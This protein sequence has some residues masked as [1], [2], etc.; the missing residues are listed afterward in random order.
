MRR[1][2]RTEPTMTSTPPSSRKV[3]LI[4]GVSSG[5]GLAAARTLAQAGFRVFGT[6]RRAIGGSVSDGIEMLALDVTDDASVERAVRA[7][8]DQAGRIDLLI[9]NA[10]IGIGAAAEESSVAQAQAL[11]DTN[12]FGTMRVTRAVLPHMR[13]QK[14][15]R[16]VNISSVLGFLPAPY[17]A[18]YAASKHAVEGYSES[19]DHEMRTLG[20]RVVLVQP[21]YTATDF[22]KNAL[23]PDQPLPV[24]D[25]A[26]AHLAMITKAVFATADQPQVVADVVLTAATQPQP[27]LR[28]PA[29][30]LARKLALLRR[31]VPASL[32][33]KS[34]RKEMRL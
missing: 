9:N 3:A 25:A 13:R 15:G 16:I 26:R 1:I 19:L 5:I 31:F 8:H 24:Y 34:L 10:G 30:P 33:D 4:T 23:G 28:Y 32:F 29:G 6:S 14:S 12:V 17:M 21:A 27:K 7:V 11:F 2:T 20:I 18:I 22:D